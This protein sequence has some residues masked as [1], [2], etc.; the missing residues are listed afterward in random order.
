MDKEEAQ[1]RWK[2]R[3]QVGCL[4][5]EMNMKRLVKRCTED[6]NERDVEESVADEHLVMMRKKE[7]MNR[8]GR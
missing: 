3:N 5:Q 6:E 8:M 7:R 2:S 1:E 4:A